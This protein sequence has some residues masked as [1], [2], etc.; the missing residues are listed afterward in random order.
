[1]FVRTTSAAL[2]AAFAAGAVA[3]LGGCGA[4]S[5][6]S[7]SAL[8]TSTHDVAAQFL[9]SLSVGTRMTAARPGAA[10][11]PKELAVASGGYIQA[12]EILNST[13]QH[14]AT[15]TD[16]IDGPRGAFYD[17][18]GDLY[19]ANVYGKNVTEYN[20]KRKL[21]FTYSAQLVQPVDVTADASGNVYV[22]DGSGAVVEFPQ[23][24]NTPIASCATSLINEGI[25]RDEATGDVFVAATP[26]SGG[27][28]LEYKRGL[29]GCNATT[30]GVVLQFVPI[31]LHIDR[32]RNLVTTDE[33]SNVDIIAPPYTS[34]TSTIAVTN[35]SNCAL[36]KSNQ[37]IF[38]NSSPPGDIVVD[39]YPSGTYVTTLNA[40]NGILNS[41]SVA[42]FPYLKD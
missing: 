40:Y 17:G 33:N 34:I 19:V 22:A 2:T 4:A 16:G 36:S 29:S 26:N 15:I 24:S 30:L 5:Q 1:M 20:S 9:T 10:K 3:V 35:P 18:R 6:S 14:V 13:Y 39:D 38:T 27:S 23:R 8:P 28:I 31:G 25:A 41:W 7:T 37:L 42:T 12:V 32:R 21:T 11:P